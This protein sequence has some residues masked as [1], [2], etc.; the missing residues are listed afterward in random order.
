MLKASG[1][2]TPLTQTRKGAEAAQVGGDRTGVA[3][4]GNTRIATPHEYSHTQLQR[5]HASTLGIEPPRQCDPG[6]PL[7]YNI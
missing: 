3:H 6:G 7:D 4:M 5:V 2:V 1:F